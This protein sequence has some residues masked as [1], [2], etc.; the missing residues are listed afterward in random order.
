MK[1]FLLGLIILVIVLLIL[2]YYKVI[3]NFDLL[4]DI[5]QSEQ[6]GSCTVYYTNS[7]KACKDKTFDPS[8][9]F[10]KHRLARIKSRIKNGRLPTQQ[11]RND[12]EKY[13]R[14]IADYDEIR[15][16]TNNTEC[17]ITLPGWTTNK[18]APFL[19]NISRNKER[20]DAPNWAYCYKKDVSDQMQK[21]LESAGFKVDTVP[22]SPGMTRIAFSNNFPY[23]QTKKAYCEET[24][25]KTKEYSLGTG[26]FIKNVLNGTPNVQFFKNG[27]AK[28]LDLAD[29]N[30]L[31]DNRFFDQKTRI[32]GNYEI[33]E[34]ITRPA[35]SCQ[36]KR[37]R[38]NACGKPVL[39]ATGSGTIQF[40]SPLTIKTVPAGT[41][42]LRGTI[43]QLYKNLAKKREELSYHSSVAATNLNNIIYANNIINDRNWR[44]NNNNGY[45]NYY[46]NSVIPWLRGFTYVHCYSYY[47]D[48]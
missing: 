17:S 12:I 3:E 8:I 31:F 29:I 2:K 43:P 22:N 4:Q 23:E 16:K 41:D 39:V 21:V 5:E 28:K 37:V 25:N 30:A 11:E 45:I 6:D 42:Y 35:N 48:C 9:Q 20:G 18:D 32:S 47:V 13:T 26:F 33:T 1:I 38:R 10:Y 46:R 15:S 40:K 36:A 24:K 19:G 44:I 34:L 7:I 27:V 14:L